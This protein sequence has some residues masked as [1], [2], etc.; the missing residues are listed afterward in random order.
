MLHDSDDLARQ[1]AADEL[2]DAEA[3]GL[4]TPIDY[5]NSRGMHAQQVYRAIR[6]KKLEDQRC[7][8][9]RRV[10]N[11]SEADTLFKRNRDA[12]DTD[13]SRASSDED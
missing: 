12:Q 1:I 13:D 5:A 4:M 2:A 9:G 8:C 3:S 6:N 10:I 7:Q 11:V